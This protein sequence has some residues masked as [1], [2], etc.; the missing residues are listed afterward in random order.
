[1]QSYFNL[2]PF[3]AQLEIIKYYPQYRSLSTQYNKENH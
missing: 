2:L 3:D 1:M